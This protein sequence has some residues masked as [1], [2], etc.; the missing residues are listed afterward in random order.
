MVLS[1]GIFTTG[2]EIYFGPKNDIDIVVVVGCMLLGCGLCHIVIPIIPEILE[3]IEQE[4]RFGEYDKQI[5]YNNVSGYYLVVIGI[6]EGFG[7]FTSSLLQ[8]S[9]KY[10][11][12]QC[13]NILC[14]ILLS[15]STIYFLTC[16][17]FSFFSSPASKQATETKPSAVDDDFT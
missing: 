4:T 13:Q 12:Q 5:L 17:T 11:I 3:A 1:I 16:G 10:T 6:G 9:F 15:V 2:S 8:A 14:L 7:P